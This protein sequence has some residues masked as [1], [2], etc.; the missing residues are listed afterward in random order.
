M[1]PFDP[2][3]EVTVH[4]VGIQDWSRVRDEIAP[5][6]R[7]DFPGVIV[8]A[9]ERVITSTT[10]PPTN[11]W[12]GAELIVIGATS[13]L[14]GLMVY[15]LERELYTSALNSVFKVDIRDLNADERRQLSEHRAK[16]GLP[17]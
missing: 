11:P 5:A 17:S 10:P 1:F 4:V 14:G 12:R 13:I 6:F 15:R 2:E 16:L 9:D 3:K 7:R 8:R